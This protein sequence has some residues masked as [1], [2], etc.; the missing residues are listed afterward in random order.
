M[1]HAVT[2][3]PPGDR[4]KWVVAANEIAARLAD[5]RYP[6]GGWLPSLTGIATELG[7][8]P[9]TVSV[10]VRRVQEAG[11]ISLAKGTGFYAGTG[12]P[13][14]EGLPRPRV[15]PKRGPSQA[16]QLPPMLAQQYITVDEL[17]VILRVSKMTIYRLVTEGAFEAIRV[18]GGAKSAIRIAAHSADAYLK[19]CVIGEGQLDVELMNG[20][21][22]A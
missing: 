15:N 16:S 11:L 9:G 6:P 14:G 7:I 18:G 12:D 13:P 8:S 1:S 21:D 4:R 20:A 2:F 17:A 22:G 3:G 5:G 10:A 19:N